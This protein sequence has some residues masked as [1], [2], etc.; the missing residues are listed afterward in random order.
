MPPLVPS[1]KLWRAP[2]AFCGEYKKVFVSRWWALEYSGALPQ[3]G[4]PGAMVDRVRHKEI[5]AILGVSRETLTKGL[6]MFSSFGAGCKNCAPAGKQHLLPCTCRCHQVHPEWREDKLCKCHG[7]PRRECQSEKISAIAAN[8]PHWKKENLHHGDTEARSEQVTGLSDSPQHCDHPSINSSLPQTERA[9]ESEGR[10]G[11][12]GKVVRGSRSTGSISHGVLKQASGAGSLPEPE[13]KSALNGMENPGPGIAAVEGE[14]F[15][16]RRANRDGVRARK[17]VGPILARNGGFRVAQSYALACKDGDRPG[18]GA[19]ANQ[20]GFLARTFGP[21]LFSLEKQRKRKDGNEFVGW[22][23]PQQSLE[24]YSK[25]GYWWHPNMP[26]DRDCECTMGQM[27]LPTQEICPKCGGDGY[28]LTSPAFKDSRG[29]PQ[30]GMTDFCKAQMQFLID[31][32]L[33]KELRRCGKCSKTFEGD[34]LCPGCGQKGDRVKKRGELNGEGSTGYSEHAIAAALGLSVSTVSRN[35]TTLKR[36]G[37]I[38]TTPGDA[39]RK[40]QNNK[41]RNLPLYTGKCPGCGS[42]SD[43]IKRRDPQLI[44]YLF[45]RTLDKEIARNE[46]ARFNRLVAWHKKWLDQKHQAELEAAVELCR[47]VLDEWEGKEHLLLSYYN[48]MRRRLGASKLR[49]N[50]VKVLF[51]FQRE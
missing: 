46:H 40:C 44:I 43:P 51:P 30:P 29:K 33:D 21:E 16:C 7:K 12:H 13:N 18:A 42:S 34:Q 3:L 22:L 8:H 23:G 19:G 15:D 6:A 27:N 1:K 39:W 37:M 35:F 50:L 41:C 20:V 24:G 4:D 47:R 48:E 28:I 9:D 14:G 17:H 38:R 26:T 25:S 10:A 2:L 5:A 49:A 45:S 11:A 36:L 31:R 32:G